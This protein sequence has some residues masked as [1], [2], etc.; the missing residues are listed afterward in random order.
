[1]AEGTMTIMAKEQNT[2]VAEDN[3][4]IENVDG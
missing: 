4:T 3:L 1:M 2:M